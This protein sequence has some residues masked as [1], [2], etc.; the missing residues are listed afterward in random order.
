MKDFN[1]IFLCGHRKSGT[2]MFLNLFDNNSEINVFPTDL[3]LLY[4]YFPIVERKLN[5]SKK[6]KIR[7]YFIQR[8]CKK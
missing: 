2:S 7:K 6:K 1:P 4:A 3:N 8:I 5:K